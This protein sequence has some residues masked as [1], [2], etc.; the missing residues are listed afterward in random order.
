MMFA[1]SVAKS[2]IEQNAA[3]PNLPAGAGR[4]EIGQLS[5]PLV[6]LSARRQRALRLTAFATLESDRTDAAVNRR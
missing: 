5:L 1:S 6:A 4:L 2:R 3:A